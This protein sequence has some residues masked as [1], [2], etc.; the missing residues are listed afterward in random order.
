MSLKFVEQFVKWGVPPGTAA[1]APV[2]LCLLIDRRAGPG[3]R[4]GRGRPPHAKLCGGFQGHNTSGTR[5]I[6]PCRSRLP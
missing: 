2:G 4:R 5:G 6:A 1:D 3:V